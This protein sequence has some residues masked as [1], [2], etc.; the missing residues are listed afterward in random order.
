MR[1]LLYCILLILSVHVEV[2]AAQEPTSLNPFA[3]VKD[4]APQ[5]TLDYDADKVWEIVE[6]R[7]QRLG[8]TKDEIEQLAT[9][10]KNYK[11]KPDNP[12][13]N[14]L[15]QHPGNSKRIDVYIQYDVQQHK[16]RELQDFR[17]NDG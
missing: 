3:L 7:L 5:D 12:Y 2:S 13:I 6:A 11:P 8:F 1:L 17:G 14:I 9:V 16:I 4:T 10:D 15:V